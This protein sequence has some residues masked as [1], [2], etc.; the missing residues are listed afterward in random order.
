LSRRKKSPSVEVALTRRALED[1]REIERYSVKEWGN[2]T[3]QKYVN[4]FAEAL[5]RIEENP[6]ILR[7]EP[8]FGCN[9]Y[10]YRMQKH[11]LVCDFHGKRVIVLTI[12][13]TGMD[14]PSRL[15]DLEPRLIA[16]AR[17]LQARLP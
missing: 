15:L 4:G 9:L 12:I 3:A 11:F 8:D 2:K 10:F 13:H 17:L 16:E 5:D 14:L 7:L 6:K 1:L